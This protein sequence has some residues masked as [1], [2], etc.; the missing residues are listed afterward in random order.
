MSRILFDSFDNQGTIVLLSKQ[1]LSINTQ[2]PSFKSNVN[3]HTNVLSLSITSFSVSTKVSITNLITRKIL[4][5]NEINPIIKGS[6][7]YLLNYKQLTIQEQALIVK[8]SC[9]LTLNTK[10]LNIIPFSVSITAKRTVNI[11]LNIKTL[12]LLLFPTGRIVN[13]NIHANLNTLTLENIHPQAK[14]SIRANTNT[15]ILTILKQSPSIKT[16][17]KYQSS[18]KNLI[19]QKFSVIAKTNVNNLIS[20][21]QI[22]INTIHPTIKGSSDY[23]ATTQRLHTYI[24]SVFVKLVARINTNPIDLNL[25]P[26]SAIVRIDI[27]NEISTLN[28]LLESFTPDIVINSINLI[29]VQ[30]LLISPRIVSVWTNSD[31]FKPIT[32]VL[33]LVPIYP[34]RVY[35]SPKIVNLISLNSLMCI[36]LK[37]KSD[38]LTNILLEDTEVLTEVSLK[39]KVKGR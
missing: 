24:N 23:L 36:E 5:I 6:S 35:P 2:N 7:H 31:Y 15:E 21:N 11:S 12:E 38:I 20:T 28:L 8:G 33:S 37:E 29:D 14:I 17:S 30:D 19:I 26:Q 3:I 9:R 4:T 16:G 27:N 39:S 34:K 32:K 13:V 1:N 18:I 22:T 25:L 10:S